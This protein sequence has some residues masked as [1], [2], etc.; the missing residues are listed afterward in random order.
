[1][2]VN[3][4]KDLAERVGWTFI[5][6]YIALGAVDWIAAGINLSLLHELYVALGAAVA[7]TIKVLIAQR[8]GTRGSGDAIPGGVVEPA[9]PPTTKAP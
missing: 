5:Q 8:V 4:A 3:Q 2:K 9:A 7:S 6:A 1:V